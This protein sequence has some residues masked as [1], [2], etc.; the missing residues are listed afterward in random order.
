MFDVATWGA[1]KFHSP[2]Y[3]EKVKYLSSLAGHRQPRRFAILQ[4]GNR[5]VLC[6]IVFCRWIISIALGVDAAKNINF[7][8]HKHTHLELY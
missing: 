1:W 5:S 2:S 6:V 8:I 4:A 3:V 7:G